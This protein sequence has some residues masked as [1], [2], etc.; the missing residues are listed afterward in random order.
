VPNAGKSTLLSTISAARPKVADYPFT[1][2]TPLLGLVRYDHSEL[3]FADVPGLLEGASEGRGLGDRFLRHIERTRVLVHL[4]DASAADPLADWRSVNH[5]LAAYSTALGERPQ[6]VVLNKIDLPDARARVSALVKKLKAAGSDDVWSVSAAT[7]EG[8]RALLDHIATVVAELPP[9]VVE[10]DE[11]P[12]LRPVAIDEDA[13]T[14]LRVAGEDAFRVSGSRV[15]RAAVVTDF[16]NPEAVDRFQRVLEALGVT[17]RLRE[18]G[19]EDGMSV[20][21]G[22]QEFEWVD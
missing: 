17:A 9:P 8:I 1:T 19:A 22:D 5:E 14:V 10:K 18:M 20:R 13:F 3:V 16:D 12:V 4:L 7:G 11:L 2:V 15:E 21:I 6:V